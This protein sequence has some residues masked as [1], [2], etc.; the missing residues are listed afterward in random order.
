MDDGMMQSEIDVLYR[1]L[2]KNQ[3]LL[4]FP[5]TDPTL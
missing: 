3:T 1:F 4:R 2:D 5:H